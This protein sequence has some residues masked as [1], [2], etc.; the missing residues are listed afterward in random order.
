M[1]FN[2]D[3][4]LPGT[5]MHSLRNTM[6]CACDNGDRINTILSR[7]GD[8]QR[9]ILAVMN[10]ERP[11]TT[12]PYQDNNGTRHQSILC[13]PDFLHTQANMRVCRL[14]LVANRA[15]S[16]LIVCCLW[17]AAQVHTR[18]YR[19]DRRPL[20]SALCLHASV[21]RVT[22]HCQTLRRLQSE[23]PQTRLVDGP[24]RSS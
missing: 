6:A 3:I 17:C 4:R 11:P 13:I 20:A 1:H 9:L 10:Q 2:D 8:I 19:V 24:R 16:H 21:N 12:Q 15:I 5:G 7:Y 22:T 23:R 14:R 18:P